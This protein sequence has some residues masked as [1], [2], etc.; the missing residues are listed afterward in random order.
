MRNDITWTAR[1]LPRRGRPG[2]RSGAAVEQRQRD[3][4]RLAGETEAAASVIDDIDLADVQTGR[5][6]VQGDVEGKGDRA[7]PGHI[8]A[9][10]LDQRRLKDFRGALQKLD[11]GQHLHA[12]LGCQ[13][14]RV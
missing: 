9:V 12:G 11:T 7:A 5:Q 2:R 1:E 4:Q 10:G 6:L 3:Q 14:Q 8:Q 13:R